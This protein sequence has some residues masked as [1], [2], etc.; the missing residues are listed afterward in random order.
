LGS[1]ECESVV[2]HNPSVHQQVVFSYTILT[3]ITSSYIFWFRELCNI[4]ALTN[5]LIIYLHYLLRILF[6]AKVSNILTC[7]LFACDE[8]NLMHYSSSVYWIST[9]LQ[10]SGLPAAHHQEAAMCIMWQLVCAVCF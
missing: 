10:G 9:P 6:K 4:K 1:S 2:T 8:T 3:W 7:N 5:C